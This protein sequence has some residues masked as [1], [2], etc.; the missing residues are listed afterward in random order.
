LEDIIEAR[1]I[2]L[3]GKI[4]G[5]VIKAEIVLRENFPLTVNDVVK[6]C[7]ENF[8]DVMVLEQIVVVEGHPKSDSGEVLKKA[9][10]AT[11]EKQ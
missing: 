6:H 9:P 3:P 5:R 4:L 1:V 10:M 11:E 7:R 2:W 8:E